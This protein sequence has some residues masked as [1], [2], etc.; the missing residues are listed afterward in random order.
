MPPD[1][2]YEPFHC[3]VHPQREAVQIRPV[4][5]L[6]IA[7]VPAVEDRLSEL[8]AV[9]FKQLT[10][11]LRA[12]PFLDST[13]LRLIL[14]WDARSRADGIAFSVVPG[15]PAVQRLFDLTGTT[16]R[17]A[18]TDGACAGIVGSARGPGGFAA[19]RAG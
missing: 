19:F 11:D 18:F 10:L 16:G 4:G 13:G 3:E 7:T 17:I 8:Q 9:G 15:P 5:E 2:R 14:E 1:P 6:D 12:V